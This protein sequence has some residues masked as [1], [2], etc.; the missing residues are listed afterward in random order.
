MCPTSRHETET[1]TCVPNPHIVSLL[2]RNWI[3]VQHT[4]FP[5][6]KI[7]AQRHGESQASIHNG[8][9]QSWGLRPTRGELQAWGWQDGL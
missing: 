2:Y 9:Q 1:R 5:E 3:S 4:H 7:K 8:E 6:R